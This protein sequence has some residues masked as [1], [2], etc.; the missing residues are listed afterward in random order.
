MPEPQIVEPVESLEK[1]KES[2]DQKIL[3]KKEAI[4]KESLEK[5]DDNNNIVSM[6]E[7]IPL[8]LDSYNF[9]AFISKMRHESCRPVLENI[10]KYDKACDLHVI[11]VNVGLLKCFWTNY[12][13]RISKK[14]LKRTNH[15]IV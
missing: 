8:D 15:F 9:D 6:T 12:L 10:K 7:N 4:V 3:E 1:E 2:I 5:N 13:H 11:S 14:W